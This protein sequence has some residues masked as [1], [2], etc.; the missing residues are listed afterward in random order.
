MV[1]HVHEEIAATLAEGKPVVALESTL[2][3]HGLPWP[4]NAQ[5]AKNIENIIRQEGAIPATIAVIS[6]AVRIGLTDNDLEILGN[7]PNIYKL[8]AAD[9][10][11]GVAMGASGGTTVAGTMFCAHRAGIRIFATGGIGGVHRDAAHSFD[12]SQDLEALSRFSVTVVCAGAKAILDLPCTLEY[13][14]TKG[15]PVIGYGTD[16]LPAFWSRSSGLSLSWRI[17]TPEEA[18]QIMKAREDFGATGGMLIANPIPEEYAL[19][20][21]DMEKIIETALEKAKSM[22]IRGKDITPWLLREIRN[23][24]ESS[25]IAPNIALL[26]NNARLA[27]KIAVA[28]TNVYLSKKK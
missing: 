22:H 13:L 18:A 9:I 24:T 8:N 12:I 16:E 19:P 7:K 28:H 2:I 10:P 14:E 17:D 4:D 11:L 27:T 20:R 25:S 3:S 5:A 6:G 1:F 15:V 21:E 26:E 23:A